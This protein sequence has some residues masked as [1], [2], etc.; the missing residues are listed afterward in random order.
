LPSLA[1]QEVIAQILSDHD[2]EIEALQARLKK[3]RQLKQGMAQQLLTG[4]I[5]LV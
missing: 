5:R 2:A 3:T 1:E 4:R